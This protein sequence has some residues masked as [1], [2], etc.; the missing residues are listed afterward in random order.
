[1]WRW[2]SV[3]GLQNGQMCNTVGMLLQG[4]YKDRWMTTGW[5]AIT[6]MWHDQKL[7]ATECYNSNVCQKQCTGYH[8][9]SIKANRMH[10]YNSIQKCHKLQHTASST[11]S[12][13]KCNLN[14]SV[15]TRTR[16][17]QIFSHQ[18]P[19]HLF[20]AKLHCWK[21]MVQIKTCENLVHLYDNAQDSNI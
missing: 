20:V 2:D 13:V 5:N 3:T 17:S 16:D 11:H 10:K 21:N 4:R 18:L 12:V 15:L 7:T 14:T 19:R 6:H 8:G 1:M 9:Y